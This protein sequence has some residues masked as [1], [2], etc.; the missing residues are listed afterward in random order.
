MMSIEAVVATLGPAYFSPIK[1]STKLSC[2]SW[3]YCCSLF[4]CCWG[5]IQQ[6]FDECKPV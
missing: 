6:R 5:M 4:W 1:V 2:T 3:F